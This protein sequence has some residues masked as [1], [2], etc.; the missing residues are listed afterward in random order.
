M[1]V[2]LAQEVHGVVLDLVVKLIGETV[3]SI[4][5]A[6]IR[7]IFQPRD[8]WDKRQFIFSHQEE[9]EGRMMR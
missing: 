7:I 8:N 5:G 4:L 3:F 6:K 1:V 9:C 2:H